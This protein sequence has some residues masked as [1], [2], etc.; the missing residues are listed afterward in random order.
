M[1]TKSIRQSVIINATPKEIYEALMDSKK[2]SGFTREKANIIR[3]V[4]GKF[5]VYN[6]YASGENLELIENKKIVQ[7]WRGSDWQEGHFSK[8]TFTLTKTKNGTKINFFQ[9]G[10]PEKNYSSIKQ[11]WIDF[12]WKPMKEMLEKK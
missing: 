12:Y 4:G 8:A 2:H 5:S 6:G 1:K 7:S 10:V 3:K 11:G 9:T